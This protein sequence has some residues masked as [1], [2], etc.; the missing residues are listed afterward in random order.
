MIFRNS[1]GLLSIVFSSFL[2]GL[3]A[4][5]IKMATATVSAS[6]VLLFRALF[7]LLFIVGLVAVHKT[8]LWHKNNHLLFFRGVT[9]G[10]AVLLY[11]IAIAK[12]PISSAAI[13]ANSYPLFATLFSFLLYRERP[14]LDTVIALL[15]AFTGTFIILDPS[16][17]KVDLWHLS[18]LVSGIL[19]GLSLT[20]IHELRKTDGSWAIVFSFLLGCLAF[21]APLSLANFY[22]PNAYEWGLLIIIGLLSTV[23]QGYYTSSF[24]HVSVSD[25]S[26]L[27]LTDTAFTIFFS[28][29][30]LKETLTNNFVVGALLVFGG[31]IYLIAR[32]QKQ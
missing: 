4:I 23:G 18:A 21:S 16:C 27:A 9:G 19:A 31:S 20:Q 5:F 12:I 22:I 10:I 25:G 6:E 17:A 32:G 29:L 11:F 8:T 14:R 26:T 7:G 1:D 13:L 15:V 24:K 2:F 28:V 3:T 30:L